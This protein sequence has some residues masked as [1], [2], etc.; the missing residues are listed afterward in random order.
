[1]NYKLFRRVFVIAAFLFATTALVAE[2]AELKVEVKPKEAF[3]FVDGKA[4]N[5]HDRKLE[6]TPGEHMI[7][8]Y[9]Y[10]FV[11]QVQK[12]TLKEGDNPE[13]EVT[14]QPAGDPVK[15]PF[16]R[17]KIEGV[18]NRDAVFLNG[19][20]TEFFIGHVDEATSHMFM[21]QK[22]ILPPGTHQVTIVDP[23]GDKEVF[24]GP[25]EIVANRETI[26][27]VEDGKVRFESWHGGSQMSQAPRFQSTAAETIVTVAPVTA[28]MAVEPAEINCA[29]PA[30]L[31]WNTTD[32]VHTTITANGVPIG[33]LPVNGEQT[34]SPRQTT[35]YELQTVGPGGVF[36]TKQTVRV[37]P[38]V[39]TSLAI[40]PAELRYRQ[41]DDLVKEQGTAT[42]KWT[43]SNAD[44]VRIDPIGPGTG[45]AGEESITALPTRT[46]FGAV[47][48]MK[49]YKIT[50]TNVCG[51]SDT[52]TAS[53]HITGSIDHEIAETM[54]VEDLPETASPLPLIGLLGLG[55][56]VS[57]IVVRKFRK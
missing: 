56:L 28:T 50:A 52:S 31:V 45:T 44:S 6:L 57:G 46:D 54:P 38:T 20:T 51:G 25:V 16:G 15:P 12:V 4:Y 24:S 43:A 10:G 17:L 48:E 34:V 3:I 18:H 42:L 55:S 32:A 21:S 2:Q 19:K 40:F 8:V 35:T 39:Q 23:R 9:N 29:Q 26:L 11:P 47:D 1:M 13:L 33:T 41:V 37:N 30:R 49:T 36:T 27:D 22:L 7:G 53:L 5:H 14:L